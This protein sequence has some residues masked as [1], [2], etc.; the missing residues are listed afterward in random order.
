M[1]SWSM[2]TTGVPCW[3]A[4]AWSCR[5]VMT[6]QFSRRLRLSNP[7]MCG[8]QGLLFDHQFIAHV[9]IGIVR[10]TDETATINL[11]VQDLVGR[12]LGEPNLSVIMRQLLVMFGARDGN[13]IDGS[14]L[15]VGDAL[16]S[17]HWI[18]AQIRM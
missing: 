9:A 10:A 13:D 15:G 14:L 8:S 5:A 7:V 1:M 16:L 6:T 12:K 17:T 3:R 11:D 2:T 18:G 4:M